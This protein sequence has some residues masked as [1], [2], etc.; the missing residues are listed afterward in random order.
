MRRISTFANV[1]QLAFHAM[2]MAAV[3][4]RPSDASIPTQELIAAGANS[5]VT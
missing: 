4:S 3:H 5:D 2:N 1:T